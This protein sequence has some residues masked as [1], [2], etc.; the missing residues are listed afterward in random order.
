M[1]VLPDVD[2]T[3]KDGGLGRV[4]SASDVL[5][6][7]GI[8]SVRQSGVALLFSFEDV[9]TKVGDGPLR[10]FLEG[11]YSQ[12]A[13]PCYA[14]VLPVASTR[15]SFQMTRGPKNR[16]IGTIAAAGT[17]ANAYTFKVAITAEGGLNEAVF[18]I[19]KNGVQGSEVTLPSDGV[20]TIPGTGVEVSFDVG[21][22]TGSE[23]SFA[24]GDFYTF[25]TAAPATTNQALLDGVDDLINASGIY[26]HI[27]VAGATGK[28][29][30]SAFAE[31]LE[32]LTESHRWT[33]GSA[34]TRARNADELTDAYI[35][36]LAGDGRGSVVSKRLMVCASWVSMTDMDGYE[37]KRSAHGKLVGRIMKNGVAIS[38]GWT[39]L[40]NLP[41]VG[42]LL[43]EPTPAQIKA[44]EDAG[45]ATCRYYDGKR[46]VYVSD[47]H[48][49]TEATS[50]F[51]TSVRIEVMNKACRVVREAQFPY[52]K[53]GFDVLPDG[54]V[55]ELEQV[56][57]A[58]EQA[59]DLMV[60]DKEISSGRIEIADNQDILRTKRISEEIVI[61]PRGQLDE[62]RATIVYENPS[63]GD[64]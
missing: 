30:W 51:D 28:S 43:Y 62:I 50:D 21:S 48:L 15:Q 8:G 52:L 3:I 27:A 61:I 44:L 23:K 9:E 26:R 16:G 2:I 55:P 20:Y 58:G 40:G 18:R 4:G 53:Q 1:G 10:D 6:A 32:K 63:I 39:R 46:G 17:P 33:W 45:Y 47:S 42:S 19:T 64:K 24:E 5:G 7:V 12:V 59:L 38:P 54:R 56:A 49:M 60:K 57:A 31:K 14:R 29:F 35:A 11:V 34:A 36:D 13:V 41:G 37:A 25:S 22:P